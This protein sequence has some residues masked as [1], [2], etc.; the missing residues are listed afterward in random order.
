MAYLEWGRLMI[1]RPIGNGKLNGRAYHLLASH[2][3]KSG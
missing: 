3:M 2:A 1:S